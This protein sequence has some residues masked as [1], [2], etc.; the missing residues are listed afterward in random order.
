MLFVDYLNI[1]KREFYNKTGIS[2]GTLNNSTGITEDTLAKIFAIYNVINSQWL[3]TGEGEMLRAP[4]GGAAAPA[5]RAPPPP[6]CPLC[7]EKEKLIAA[8]QRTIDI[9]ERELHH[10][11]ALH[12]DER[13]QGRHHSGGQKRKAG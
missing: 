13:N 5:H 12:D 9:L 2:R 1:S 3:L 4:D 8:Q 11:K 10:A 7:A 6:G